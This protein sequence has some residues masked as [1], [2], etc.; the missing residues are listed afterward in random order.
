MAQI[1]IRKKLFIR[2]DSSGRSIPGSAVYRN[3][4]PKIG[5]WIEVTANSCCTTTTTAI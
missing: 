1:N 3:S 5:R 2:I 4:I